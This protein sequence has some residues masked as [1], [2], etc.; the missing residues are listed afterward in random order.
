[1]SV[2]SSEHRFGIRFP[3]QT[4]RGARAA[5]GQS[6]RRRRG[7]MG[8]WE[9]GEGGRVSPW[10]SGGCRRGLALLRLLTKPPVWEAHAL[11]C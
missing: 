3:F 6:R 8:R 2:A 10:T 9:G 5:P 1:M 4:K 7:G 11:L